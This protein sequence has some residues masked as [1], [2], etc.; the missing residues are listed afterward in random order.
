MVTH[1]YY[2]WLD[3]S[4]ELISGGIG[5]VDITNRDHCLIY[6]IDSDGKTI[7]YWNEKYDED[8]NLTGEKS[9]ETTCQYDADGQ[10]LKKIASD[11]TTYYTY[12]DGKLITERTDNTTIRY[13]Y[14]DSGQTQKS[15]REKDGNVLSTIEYTYSMIYVPNPRETA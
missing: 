12:Q 11:G 9:N 8:G 15:V 2:L 7:Q 13:E 1:S 5:Q 6:M 14:T 10:I 4:G 3:E